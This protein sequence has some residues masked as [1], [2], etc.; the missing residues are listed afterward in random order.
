MVEL[1]STVVWL[2]VAALTVAIMAF[3]LLCI[4]TAVALCYWTF[5][6]TIKNIK[7]ISHSGWPK[8]KGGTK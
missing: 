3:V 2:L 6:F 4:L 8:I 7:A 1:T 5:K